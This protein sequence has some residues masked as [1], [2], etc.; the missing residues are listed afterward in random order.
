MHWPVLMFQTLHVRS[1]EPE[2]Q[3]SPADNRGMGGR[4]S[5]GIAGKSEPLRGVHAFLVH[6]FCPQYSGLGERL[7]CQ[8]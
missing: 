1:M 6:V 7:H 5:Y 4:K 3:R 2:I 8:I